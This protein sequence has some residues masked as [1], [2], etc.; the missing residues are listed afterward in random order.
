MEGNGPAS[1]DAVNMNIILI[2]SD[3]V[4]IDSVYAS[5][6][7]VNSKYVPTCVYGEMY[8]LGNRD[9]NNIDIVTPIGNITIEEAI[10]KYG[11]PDFNVNRKKTNLWPITSMFRFVKHKPIVENELVAFVIK[12]AGADSNVVKNELMKYAST[13]FESWEQ[14]TE[15]YVV[16]EIPRSTVGKIDYKML[17]KMEN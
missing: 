10:N 14:P 3:P 6:V 5:L 16:D 9:L 12:K 11:K 8:G 2:S 17:E 4:A 13:S 15:Y 7:Y 1:G